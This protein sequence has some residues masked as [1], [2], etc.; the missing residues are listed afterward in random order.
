MY[1]FIALNITNQFLFLNM[2]SMP[3]VIS[4]YGIYCVSKEAYKK[5]IFADDM[6]S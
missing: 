4:C 6:A 2:Y 3:C 1:I 5:Y